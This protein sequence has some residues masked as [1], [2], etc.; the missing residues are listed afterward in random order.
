MIKT[1]L[2]GEAGM[3]QAGPLIPL[4]WHCYHLIPQLNFTTFRISQIL[5]KDFGREQ[6][7]LFDFWRKTK[8]ACFNS[9]ELSKSQQNDTTRSH[10]QA[11]D[12]RGASEAN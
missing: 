7:K 3:Y 8:F 9:I 10:C 6:R 2:W 12:A 11:G 5:S 1:F 4:L